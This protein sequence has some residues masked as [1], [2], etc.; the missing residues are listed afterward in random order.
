[1]Q[2]VRL[3]MHMSIMY[4]RIY[5]E[6]YFSIPCKSDQN[7]LKDKVNDIHV[8]FCLKILKW[9]RKNG[10]TTCKMNDKF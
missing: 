4:V 9:S 3:L 8:T 6:E 7:V 2:K 5:T 1:M 10:A